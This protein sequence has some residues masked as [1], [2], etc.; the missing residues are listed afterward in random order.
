MALGS[1]YIGNLLNYLT[2]LTAPFPRGLEIDLE[3]DSTFHHLCYRGFNYRLG[4]FITHSS[5]LFILLSCILGWCYIPPP[6][7]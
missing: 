4:L 6:G 5:S 7:I 3:G 1:I 2:Y